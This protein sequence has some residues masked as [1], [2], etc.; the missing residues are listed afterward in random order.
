[1]K[2]KDLSVKVIVFIFSLFVLFF[3]NKMKNVLN[4]SDT[5]VC[6]YDGFGYY[7]YTPYLLSEGSYSMNSEWAQKLQN[8]YCGGNDVY[9]LIH[10]DNGNEINI[11]HMGLS[12]IQIPSYVLGDLG[13]HIFGY[14]KDGFSIPY[15]ISYLLN[16]LVFILFGLIYLRKL[17]KL[18]FSDGIVTLVILS[19]FLGSNILVT[20]GMQFS[21]THLYLFSLNAIFL[22][23]LFRYLQTQSKKALIYSALF[24]GLTVCIR[25]TQII[26]GLIPVFLF[27]QAHKGD[28]LT[29]IKKL[30]WFPLFGLLWNI[31]QILYWYF[32]GGHFIMPNM[33]TEEI[34]IIDPNLIDFLFSY[35]KGWLLYSP[36]FFLLIIGFIQLY[37]EKRHFFWMSITFAFVYILVMS[38]WECWWYASSFGSRVMV[39]I[40]PFLAIVLGYSFV[41][42]SRN[43]H[44]I[45]ISSYCAICILFSL[46]QSFQFHQGI[47]HDERMTKEQ[48]WHIFG[49]LD[50]HSVSAIRLEIDRNSTNWINDLDTYSSVG[51]KH[52]NNTVLDIKDK[53]VAIPGINL[54]IDKFELLSRVPTDE[55]CF[56]VNFDVRTS[57]S[58]KNASLQMETVSKYNC[59]SWNNYEISLNNK[60]NE[61]THYSV[62]YSL[63]NLRHKG[64]K[65][66]IYIYNPNDI[67]VEIANLKIE[68]ISL[69]R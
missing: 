18:Y 50:K 4:E 31:P 42:F 46:L 22:Y 32:I 25:P 21:L 24:L 30:L 20:F 17:L 44:R 14:K 34:I 57:D 2:T 28:K 66:Q 27:F 9:Q 13:A 23:H 16:V 37:K 52:E 60:Q 61:F 38:S 45:L 10:A 6:S 41:A 54:S 63:R 43:S 64:D 39:D 69:I 62:Q 15:Y 49:K 19:L 55:T 7:M 5:C 58:T 51:I 8:E 1:M 3:A 36:I 56:T 59:Y 35:K 53:L 12:F 65:M 33:H 26:L 67:T 29:A 68:A 48:Y 47:L 40:Y 11:Y